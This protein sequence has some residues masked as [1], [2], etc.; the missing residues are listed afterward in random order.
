[1]KLLTVVSGT[2]LDHGVAKTSTLTFVRKDSL[3]QQ[4]DDSL[5]ILNRS[6]SDLAD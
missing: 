2:T 3:Q 1:M 5:E 4:T 6:K